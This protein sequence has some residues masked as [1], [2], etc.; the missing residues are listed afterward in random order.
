MNLLGAVGP[1]HVGPTTAGDAATAPFPNP[2]ILIIEDNPGDV[3]LVA[4]H[5]HDMTMDADVSTRE[6]LAEAVAELQ[7]RPAEVALVDLE[8]PDSSGSQTI[9]TLHDAFPN[10]ALIALTD[11][12]NLDLAT[13][14]IHEGAQDFLAKDK[15]TA[16]SLERSIRF[17]VERLH[18]TRTIEQQL[19]LLSSSRRSLAAIFD[20][21]PVPML[22]L[23][24][25][26]VVTKANSAAVAEAGPTSHGTVGH[27][28]GEALRCLNALN[29]PAGCGKNPACTSCALRATVISVRNDGRRRSAVSCRIPVDDSPSSQ[30]NLLVAAAPVTHDTTADILVCLENVTEKF[31][32][33]RRIERLNRLLRTAY[34]IGLATRREKREF[35]LLRECCRIV[36]VNG[37]YVAAW[38]SQPDREANDLEVVAAYGIDGADWLPGALPCRRDARRCGAPSEALK[39]QQTVVHLGEAALQW[40]ERT[41]Y[42]IQGVASFPM[43]LAN[44]RPAVLSVAS[45]HDDSFDPDAVQLLEEVSDDLSHALET[46]R[47]EAERRRFEAELRASEERHRNL[48]ERNVAGVFRTTP[49]GEILLANEAMA[50]IFGY[51]HVAE[52]LEVNDASL[53]AD[54]RDRQ[55]LIDEYLRYGEV[56][57]FEAAM[58]TRT[59]ESAWVLINAVSVRDAATGGTLIEGTMLDV[60][61]TRTMADQLHHAQ[62]MEAVG[63]LAGGVAHEFNNL[64]QAMS[65]TVE[66]LMSRSA[67]AAGTDG[68]ALRDV[69]HLIERGSQVA[70]QL[71]VFSRRETTTLATVAI[72]EIA[73]DVSHMLNRFLRE[74]VELELEIRDHGLVVEADRGQMEQVLVNLALNAQ[75]AMQE[76]GRLTISVDRHHDMVRLRVRDTG[77]GIAP[78]DLDRIFE[79]F[80]TTKGS[81]SGTGLGLSVVHGI[82]T[83]FGG[84]VDVESRLGHGTSFTILLPESFRKPDEAPAADASL[85]APNRG[86]GQTILVI[87]DEAAVR[88]GLT[89]ILD[90]LGYSFIECADVTEVDEE[91]LARTDLVLSDLVLPGGSGFDLCRQIRTA[92]P[93]LP[94][95]LMSG[96]SAD[97]TSAGEIDG[98]VFLPKPFT[99]SQVGAAIARLLE[100]AHHGIG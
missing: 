40:R 88:E 48:V 6:T 99:M 36:V 72:D 42:E 96:Y 84:T 54:P 45:L 34:E 2:R 65:S 35:P 78:A 85:P 20:S 24:H 22:V 75:D 61:D 81:R 69:S 86:A 7:K 16:D 60:T 82:I 95:V 94:V 46:L 83:R 62:R 26:L 19:E 56:R 23:D 21:T 55:R 79:P 43:T 77:T 66:G 50:R 39:M 3:R 31:A 87:E 59:G 9:R 29:D 98:A 37:G 12:A 52:L 41:G 63:R 14:A 80:F 91:K 51:D 15:V 57:N 38:V 73:S 47:L 4:Q 13:E 17:A 92:H 10:L 76:G 64:L 58:L 5:L 49:E 32:A 27:P 89:A 33:E 25:D 30:K 1:A 71:L 97:A 100:E 68:P 90:I 11:Q 74:S 67:T 53:Y 93:D 28:I 70:R 44:R 18:L 8:L